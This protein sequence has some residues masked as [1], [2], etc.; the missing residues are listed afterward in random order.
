MASKR[1]SS[2]NVQWPIANHRCPIC[3]GAVWF[4]QDQDPDPDWRELVS[5]SVEDRQA[6]LAEEKIVLI[7]PIPGIDKERVN[8]TNGQPWIH[9]ESLAACGYEDV[10]VGTVIR[11]QGKTKDIFFE[12]AG[13]AS[14]K[15]TRWAQAERLPGWWLIRIDGEVV[16]DGVPEDWTTSA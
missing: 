4:K 16:P 8:K 12:L 7:E 2:C 5:K 10:E 9:D 6:E 3:G 15:E 11:V 14:R 13:R 1:C